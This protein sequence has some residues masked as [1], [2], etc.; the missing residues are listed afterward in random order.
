MPAVT[1]NPN[2]GTGTLSNGNLTLSLSTTGGRRDAIGRSSGR[3]YLEMT[4]VSGT[5]VV[6]GI[7]QSDVKLGGGTE[8][9]GP[10]LLCYNQNGGTF[11]GL[12]KNPEYG[13][14]WSEG[15]VVGLA[16]DLDFGNCEFFINGISQGKLP[17]DLREIFNYPIFVIV[18]SN[19]SSNTK[20]ITMN[21][22]GSPF[23]YPVPSGFQP[24]NSDEIVSPSTLIKDGRKILSYKD[25]AWY[26][27]GEVLTGKDMFISYGMDTKYF[28]ERSTHTISMSMTDNG[29]LGQGK[30]FSY[31]LDLNKFHQIQN[32]DI[33]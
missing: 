14:K 4:Q 8:A 3:W 6:F 17:V 18:G 32:L 15:D 28:F 26:E 30:T 24:Y 2:V 1:L 16:I 21:F 13:I 33:S 9:F 27:A 10:N 5:G 22:G 19:T 20:K 23:V 31:E 7:G 25:N 12:Y 29:T 11:S